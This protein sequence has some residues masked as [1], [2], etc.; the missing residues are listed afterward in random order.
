MIKTYTYGFETLDV[1][2]EE[3]SAMMGYSEEGVPEPFHDYITQALAYAP[4]I[5]DIRGGYRILDVTF[6]DR[7][8]TRLEGISFDTNDMVT[9]FLKKS[10]RVAVF[11]CTAGQG[12][13]DRIKELNKK[14][15]L[16]EGYTLDVIGSITVE[17]AMDKIQQSLKKDISRVGEHITNRYSPGYCGWD[18][19]E[20]VNLFSLLPDGFCDITLTESSL[21]IP[22]KSV[23][24]FIGIGKDVAYRD[25][26]CN[27]CTSEHCIYRRR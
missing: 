16:S 27:S 26:V 5:S 22:T 14:G 10:T 2:P 13:S 8:T 21:M 17:R 20:Q 24:G 1:T 11:V 9:A 19:G 18:T 3:V 15:M 4:G 23:S 12:I 25:Y 6:P 7:R